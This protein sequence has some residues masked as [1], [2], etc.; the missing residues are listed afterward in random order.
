MEGE[1]K[2]FSLF[3]FSSHHSFP[4]LSKRKKET[5]T[6]E[7]GRQAEKENGRKAISE[8]RE[9]NEMENGRR[10]GRL[11]REGEALEAGRRPEIEK[12]R[13]DRVLFSLSVSIS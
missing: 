1:W 6:L 5:G 13:G 12:W 2:I 9:G 7:G 10:M 3:S 11:R 4:L 8:G